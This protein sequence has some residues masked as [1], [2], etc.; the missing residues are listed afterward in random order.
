MNI[1]WYA[2]WKNWRMAIASS[3][4]TSSNTW[5]YDNDAHDYGFD[6]DEVG[7]YDYDDGLAMMIDIDNE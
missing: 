4:Q 3:E 5:E 6:S 2:T 7:R 1:S